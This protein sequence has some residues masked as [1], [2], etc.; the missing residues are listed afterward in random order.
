MRTASAGYLL[1]ALALT[2][3]GGIAH[4]DD[5]VAKRELAPTGKLRVGIAVASTPGAGNVARDAGGG[6]RGVAVDLGAELAATLGVPAEFVPYPNSGALTD[7]VASG[8]LR[9]VAVDAGP[10]RERVRHCDVRAP[11]DQ[12]RKGA[13]HLH[14]ADVF[15]QAGGEVAQGHI[16]VVEQAR[17][18]P[19]KIDRHQQHRHQR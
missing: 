11:R 12:A 14:A 18:A 10:R 3:V 1:I 7:A 4:A 8:E 13:H 9:R 19:T 16:H 5:A 17:G 2:T 15:L 6:Y